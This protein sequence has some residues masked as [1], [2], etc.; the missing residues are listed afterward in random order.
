MA[1]INKVEITDVDVPEVGKNVLD[2]SSVTMLDVLEEEKELEEEYAA[3]LG[4]SDEKVCTYAQG[5]VKRQALY[6]CL[7][8]CPESRNDLSKCAGVCLACTYQC[9]ENHE[10][11]ELYTK[12]N[13]CCD[14]PTERMGNSNRCRLNPG[15]KQAVAANRDN[16]YNQ[17]FQGLYCNCHRPYPDPERTTEE[18]MLQCGICEDWFHLNHLD[19]PPIG[20][21]L[22]EACSEMI[23]SGCMAKHEFLMYYTGLSLTSVDNLNESVTDGNVTIAGEVSACEDDDNKLKSDL[24]KSISEIMNMGECDDKSVADSEPLCKKPKLDNDNNEAKSK[25]TRPTEKGDYV[26]GPTFW[27]ADWRNSLCRCPSCMLIYKKENV[28]YLLDSEDSA[29]SYEERGMQ[30]AAAESSYEQGI[31]ALASIDRVQ[32][33]DVITEYNRMKDRLKD[34]LQTFV[35]SKKVVTEDDINRFFSEIRNEKNVE[36][37]VP[38]FCR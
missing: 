21:K 22:M 23:C 7:T 1:N 16:L 17:N 37:G 5:A 20:Q 10:L 11:V 38:H 30:K 13:F 26:K 4:A 19:G 35:A 6:S 9:H 12:R 27:G 14:C 33:I 25:C 15:L 34:Y 31:R 3:V 2:E 18:V 36:I 8:C 24:D 29:K 28:E 32:Q